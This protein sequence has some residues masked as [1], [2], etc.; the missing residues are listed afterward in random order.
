MGATKASLTASRIRALNAVADEGSF[1]AAARRLGAS[2]PAVSQAI[3]EL[4][5]AFNVR[6]FERRGRRLV[7]TELCLELSPIT[8]EIARQEEKILRLMQRGE[9]VETGVLRIA[10][11]SMTPSMAL[12]SAFQQ[13]FPGIQIHL[14]YA[15]FSQVIDAVLEGRADIGIL[16]D[17]PGDGRFVKKTCLKQDI[18]ALVPLGH[19]FAGAARLSV[20][21]LARERLIFQQKGSVTQKHVDT[22]FRHAGLRPR[23]S[24]ILKTHAEVYEAVVNGLGLGFIWRHATT[25]KDG[26][27]RIPVDE[28]DTVYAEEVFRLKDT[29]NPIVDRFFEMTDRVELA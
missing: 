27:R 21:D 23:P 12:V 10:T 1:A 20:H 19:Q 26:T 17:V 2:Q 4:E 3:Q 7:P 29:E 8:N 22:A 6:L 5:K 24:L 18:V 14:E 25:R 28:V 11:G 16:P 9:Q 15:I 13:R